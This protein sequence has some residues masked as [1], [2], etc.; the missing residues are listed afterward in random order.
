MKEQLTKIEEK[1]DKV[2]EKLSS[3]DVTLARQAKDLEHHI[4]RTSLAE[5]NIELLRAEVQPIKKHVAL[6]DAGLKIIGALASVVTVIVGA[7][8]L[9]FG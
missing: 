6:M 2:D 9:I 5:E 7:I 3:I 4:F 8:K 1:L